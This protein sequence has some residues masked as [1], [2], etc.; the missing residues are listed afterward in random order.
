MGAGPASARRGRV[1]RLHPRRRPR[2]RVCAAAH[3][4]ARQRPG[5]EALG[6]RARGSRGAPGERDALQRGG[7]R[8]PHPA[9]TPGRDHRGRDLRHLQHLEARPEGQGQRGPARH[10]RQRPS[11]PHRDG[12]GGRGAADRPAD[13]GHHP[14]A[15]CAGAEDRPLL[16]RRSR[17]D[18]RHRR[19]AHRTASSRP[20][21]AGARGCRQREPWPAIAHPRD[22]RRAR[23]AAVSSGGQRVLDGRRRLRRRG[24]LRRR[25]RRRLLGRGGSS[26]GGG[27][28]GS[29]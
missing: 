18:G 22:V 21:D 19:G 9:V 17:G 7:D 10:R 29:Y 13:A 6:D 25:R 28:S 11:R 5:R 20:A 24:R 2:A 14:A 12:Q 3:P 26:G 1:P 15:D 8:G 27:S 16:R 23:V 4:G